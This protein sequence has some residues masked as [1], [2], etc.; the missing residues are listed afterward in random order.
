MGLDQH[1]NIACFRLINT[2]GHNWLRIGFVNKN[3]QKSSGWTYCMLHWHL[4]LY[5]IVLW[6]Y[7]VRLTCVSSQHNNIFL[8]KIIDRNNFKP[9]L[10]I[11][12]SAANYSRRPHRSCISFYYC[13][14]AWSK[15]A[16]KVTRVVRL[17]M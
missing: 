9:S 8:S 13:W 16:F 4:G 10:I 12:I 14:P 6:V 7:I 2:R 17:G 3:P 5:C 11:M 15:C 1:R